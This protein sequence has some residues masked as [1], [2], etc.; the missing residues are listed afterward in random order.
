MQLEQ[1]LWEAFVNPAVCS[2][3]NVREQ[4]FIPKAMFCTDH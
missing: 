1:S 4:D 3:Q 2:D